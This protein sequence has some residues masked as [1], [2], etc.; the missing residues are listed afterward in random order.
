M[1]PTS[2]TDPKS[3]Q[4]TWSR[5]V[6]I[7]EQFRCIWVMP[8]REILVGPHIPPILSPRLFF[9]APEQPVDSHKHIHRS[10]HDQNRHLPIQIIAS[11][12][13]MFL[14]Y[15]LKDD[16]NSDAGNERYWAFSLIKVGRGSLSGKAYSPMGLFS[17]GASSEV[18]F[19][20]C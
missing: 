20:T 18:G 14:I 19:M 13:L 7:S 11:T 5:A 8:L 17:S 2:F 1:L 10:L 16:G 6:S 4:S 9:F 15:T 3:L 12:M